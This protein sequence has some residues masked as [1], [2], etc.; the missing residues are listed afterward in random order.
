MIQEEFLGLQKIAFPI[1]WNLGDGSIA[2]YFN[3]C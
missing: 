1:N 2:P 3:I